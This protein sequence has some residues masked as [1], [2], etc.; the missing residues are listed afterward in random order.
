[1]A[2]HIIETNETTD[3]VISINDCQRCRFDDE[4]LKVIAKHLK[5]FDEIEVVG[6][7][8]AAIEKIAN[9]FRFMILVRSKSAGALMRALHS[10]ES[11]PHI[12]IDMDPVTLL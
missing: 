3:P 7:G 9:T 8:A 5:T 12:A 10:L 1:M 2:A 11:S 6:E 4:L